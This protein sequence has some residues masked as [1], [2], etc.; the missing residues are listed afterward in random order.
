MQHALIAYSPPPD[1]R[2]LSLQGQPGCDIGLMIE[3][4]H[5]DF[6]TVCESLAKREAH[7]AN[8]RGRVHPECDLIGL[9]RVQKNCDIFPRAG[10]RGVDFLA[11]P[12][13]STSL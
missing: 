9:S 8:E 13:T 4:S 10:D 2:A 1:D 7:Q 3:V 6:A 12:V 5:N 11:F